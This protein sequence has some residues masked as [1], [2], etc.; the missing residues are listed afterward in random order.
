MLAFFNLGVQE[1]IIL[2]FAALALLAILLVVLFVTRR[3]QPRQD[4]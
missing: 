1:L 2:A 3:D 4:E